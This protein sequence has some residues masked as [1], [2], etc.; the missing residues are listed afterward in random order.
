MSF[1]FFLPATNSLH[2]LTPTTR[3][4]P[5]LP[6]SIFSWSS[7]SSRPFQFLSADLFGHP[8]LLHSL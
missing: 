5:L 7:P 1:H 3:R 4:S 8:I 6:L 2:L